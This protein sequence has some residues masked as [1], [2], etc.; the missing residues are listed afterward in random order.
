VPGD[1]YLWTPG[2]WGYTADGYYWVP[3]VWVQAPYQGALWT[4]GYWG[5]WNHHYGFYHGYWGPHIGY[6]GGINYGF[7]YIGFGYQGGY[8]GGG[9]FHYNRTVN[10]INISVVHDAYNRPVAQDN[11]GGTRVSFNGGQGGLHVRARPAELAARGETHTAPMSAQLQN[12]HS[13]STNRA[14]FTHGEQGRPAHLAVSQPLA[15]D[16]NVRAPA[17]LQEHNPTSGQQRGDIETH[18]NP[19]QA[20]VRSGEPA[21]N[22]PVQN[23]RVQNL[24]ERNTVD[25]STP[26]QQPHRQTA[27]QRQSTPPERPMDVQHQAAP[28]RE[29]TSQGPASASQHPSAPQT[30]RQ[31]V[32]QQTHAAEPKPQHQAAPQQHETSAAQEKKDEHPR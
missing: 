17:S 27:P 29:G 30:Q 8:W 3:G 25:R 14:Q 21:R 6:Y 7:G 23:Q 26:A 24:P 28:V 32:P 2:Y 16:R 13:A 11:G 20:P 19:V 31:V 22:Q 1:G 18:P 12:E 4:P 15:A 10:N 9:H 5:Y